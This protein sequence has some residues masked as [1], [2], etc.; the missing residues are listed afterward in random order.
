[1]RLDDLKDQLG[2][3]IHIEWKSFMLRQT[4]AGRKTRQ[5]F[6]EYSKLWAP[7]SDLDPRLAVT[8]PWGSQD[9]H[10]SHS[11][12]A[13]AASKLVRTFGDDIEAEFHHRMFKAYFYE[14]RTIS[15]DDVIAAIAGEA[16]LDTIDFATKFVEQ[17]TG[18]ERE[19]T[20][21]HNEAIQL[22]VTAVPT[23]IVNNRVAIPGAQETETYV[24]VINDVLA[25]R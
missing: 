10:P 19:V 25:R 17:R 9:P 24:Q 1:V 4:E 21:D 20:N 16:G 2:D 23:V 11:L 12:P 3:R 18:L 5:E 14:N 7:M 22:G 13:L 6:L 8:A 15:D